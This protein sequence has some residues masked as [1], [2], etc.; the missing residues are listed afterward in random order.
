MNRKEFFITVWEF[1]ISVWEKG[2]KPILLIGI[3]FFCIKFLF[4]AFTESGSERFV[5]IFA[6]GIGLLLL[7]IHLI[8]MIFKSLTKKLNS[9]LP[10]S[11]KLCIRVIGKTLNYMSPIIFGII[12]YHFWNENSIASVI[13]LG[14]LLIQRIGEIIKEEKLTTT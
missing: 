10:E 14:I 13:I 1:L 7:T 8:K 12:I 6:L 9:I 3:I 11:I 5:I 2:I 4:N